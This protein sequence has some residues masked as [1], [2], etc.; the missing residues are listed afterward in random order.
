VPV[1]MSG[2]TLW[3]VLTVR[4]NCFSWWSKGVA[5]AHFWVCGVNARSSSHNFVVAE[6]NL[7]ISLCVALM[8]E[9]HS[10]A[11]A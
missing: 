5:N 11:I 4:V 6:C 7:L 10:I 9:T 1:L 2:V 8:L 3:G